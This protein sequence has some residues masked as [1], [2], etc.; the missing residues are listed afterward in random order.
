MLLKI[1]N[2]LFHHGLEELKDIYQ[3]ILAMLTL[4]AELAKKMGPNSW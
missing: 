2:I 1:I 3:D 4:K